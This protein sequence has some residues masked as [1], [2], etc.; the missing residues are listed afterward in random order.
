MNPDDLLKLQAIQETKP[1]SFTIGKNET[2]DSQLVNKA[3]SDPD[4]WEQRALL[5]GLDE[6]VALLAPVEDALPPYRAVF[7]PHDNPNLLSDYN[8]KKATLDAAAEGR[9]RL[10]NRLS[11][12]KLSHMSP[13]CRPIQASYYQTSRL[14]LSLWPRNT[15]STCGI[16]YQPICQTSTTYRKNLYSRP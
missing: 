1:D 7:S 5:R 3:F 2:H 10:F 11:S 13:R 9:C 14:C 4:T 8:V 12:A 15:G 16:S 6:I